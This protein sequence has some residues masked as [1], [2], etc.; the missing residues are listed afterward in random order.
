M[1]AKTLSVFPRAASAAHIPQPDLDALHNSC[2]AFVDPYFSPLSPDK[3][4]IVL[5]WAQ[6]RDGKICRSSTERE[7]LSCWETWY[8]AHHIR[9]R[10]DA[11]VVGA[12]TAVTDDPSLSG[13]TPSITTNVSKGTVGW[14]GKSMATCPNPRTTESRYFGSELSRPSQENL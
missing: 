4:H 8:L 10:S 11:I 5:T 1:D 7:N 14:C 12:T 2:S 9:R 3:P 13:D 6:S